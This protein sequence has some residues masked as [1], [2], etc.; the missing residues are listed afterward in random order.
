V[1]LKKKGARR[2][3]LFHTLIRRVLSPKKW[4]QSI[5]TKLIQ[6]EQKLL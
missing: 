2:F 3:C 4:D 1:R 6:V 5:K